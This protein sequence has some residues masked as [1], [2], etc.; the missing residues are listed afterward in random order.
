MVNSVNC[1]EDTSDQQPAASIES[2]RNRQFFSITVEP[3]LD[4]IRRIF[5]S[6][7]FLWLA[8]A[9]PFVWLVNAWRTEFLF[10]GEIIHVS[11]E[12]SARL[13][14][15]TMAITP[16]RILFPKSSWPLWLQSRRRYFGVATFAFAALHAVV[17]VDRK[18]SLDLILR[19]GAG[20][21]M[22]TG[23]VALV[24]FIALAA[25]S[26]DQSVRWLKNGW[27]K[28]HRW[29]YAAALLTFTHWI[30]VAFDFVPG[31]VH[32]LLL[33]ALESCR[34]WKHRMMKSNAA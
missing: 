11:G 23:W 13:L 2:C 28:L 32:F 8:L 22:W 33:L 1:C 6:R 12:W 7:V 5:N 21:S 10:Y 29:V 16:F 18:E 27:K 26:N 15:L 9:C 3:I 14:M 4:K 20:F 25:T 30:F 17:Y 31:L 19:E 24:I 34:V